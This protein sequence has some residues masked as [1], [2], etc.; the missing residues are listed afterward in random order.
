MLPILLDEGLPWQVAEAFRQL[1]LDAHA[2]G[3]GDAPKRGSGDAVNVRLC[4][5]RGGVLV[6][7]DRGKKDRTIFDHLATHRAHA[8]FV[9]NDLR[10]APHHHLARALLIA[11]TDMDRI[12]SLSA[13]LI[14]HRLK[15][16]GR[17]EKR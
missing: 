15:P 2:V 3:H 7:N 5:Q 11:E 1:G 8:I 13:G 10:S 16:T 17:L 6:T 14:R 12:Y 4:A 9:H